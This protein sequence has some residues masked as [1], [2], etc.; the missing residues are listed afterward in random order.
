MDNKLQSHSRCDNNRKGTHGCRIFRKTGDVKEIGKTIQLEGLRK[1]G[2]IFPFEF[3]MSLMESDDLL[4]FTMIGREIT[5]RLLAL[6]AMR[7]SEEKY[8]SLF[9]NSSDAVVIWALDDTILD[10]NQTASPN[11]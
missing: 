2:T 10:I 9:E 11:A 5:E 1:D 8:R 7:E 4:H 6:E 3:T